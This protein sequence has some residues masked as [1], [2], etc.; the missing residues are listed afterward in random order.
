MGSGTSDEDIIHWCAQHRAIWIHDDRGAIR[1][2]HQL[3]H[4]S[5]VWTVKM[6]RGRQ[7]RTGREQ[8]RR[9]AYVLPHL[10]QKWHDSHNQRSPERHHE[11]KASNDKSQI[12][13]RPVRRR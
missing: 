11:I 9:L 10:L 3:L 1:E 8:L 13:L 12:S 4:T 7:G 5:G 2:N 6:A